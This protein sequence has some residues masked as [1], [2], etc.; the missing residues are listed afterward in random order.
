[1]KLLILIFIVAL[2]TSCTSTKKTMNSWIGYTKQD[3]VLKWGQ[4][5]RKESDENG[6][7]IY[8]YETEYQSYAT[9]MYV[10]K[11]FYIDSDGKIYH[12]RTQ[13]GGLPAQQMNISVYRVN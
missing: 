6:G 4:P 10:H 8:V 7:Q 5:A 11:F 3:L 2:L 13:R 12:W 1:M 9:S